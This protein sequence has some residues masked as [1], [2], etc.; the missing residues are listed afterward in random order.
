MLKIFWKIVWNELLFL[1]CIVLM[2]LALKQFFEISEQHSIMVLLA[3]MFAIGYSTF[4]D[5]T[6]RNKNT[7]VS[8]ETKT[9]E[10]GPMPII[11]KDRHENDFQGESGLS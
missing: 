3:S 4:R 6:K 10:I 1:L 7:A 5:E 11:I 2:T 8:N 9:A